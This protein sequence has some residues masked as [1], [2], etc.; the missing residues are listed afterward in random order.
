MRLSGSI[1]ALATPFAADGSLDLAAWATLVESQVGAGSM[2]VVVAGSTGEAAALDEGEYDRLLTEAVRVVGGR[3]GVIAGTGLS[4][5]AKTIAQTR[6]AAAL[7]AQAALVVTPPYVRPTQAG[8]VAHYRA[9]ADA[10]GL[11][12]VLYNVPPRTG[13]DLQPDTV[14]VLADHPN[15]LGLKEARGDVERWR[16]LAPLASPTFALLSGD[17]PTFLMAMHHGAAG[18]VSVASN[19]VPATFARI[20]ADARGGRFD[21]AEA[22]DR[23]LAPLYAFL[24]AA[25][26]PIPLKA[27]LG[28]LGLG[29][30]LR[31]PLLPLE[32]SLASGLDAVLDLVAR[33]EAD[34]RDT[35]RAA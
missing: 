11:P 13:V 35:C 19:L 9:V 3:I 14:A 34:A 22:R 27:A 25:P 12:V 29:V 8:L 20:A 31:L 17:D 6:R 2:A 26:N 28:A 5:T 23:A 10:G 1:T 7:G 32:P 21:D 4:G 24:G 30:G 15:I 16:A 33:V 18:V